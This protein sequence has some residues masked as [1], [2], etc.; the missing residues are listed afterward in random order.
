MSTADDEPRGDEPAAAEPLE[1]APVVRP[2]DRTGPP[3]RP[4]QAGQPGREPEKVVDTPPGGDDDDED[5][6]AP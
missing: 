2:E 4:A 1:S 3:E 5:V 6:P